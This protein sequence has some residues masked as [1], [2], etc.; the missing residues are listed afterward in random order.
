MS[1]ERRTIIAAIV[2]TVFP[3]IVIGLCVPIV[4]ISA[5]TY[6]PAVAARPVVAIEAQSPLSSATSLTIPPTLTGTDSALDLRLVFYG[7]PKI[8]VPQSGA[9]IISETGLSNIHDV[10]FTGEL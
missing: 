6:A 3:C 7:Y 2:A 9:A 8:G 10:T 4:S 1:E 5:G